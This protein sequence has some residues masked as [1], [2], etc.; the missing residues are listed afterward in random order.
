[1]NCHQRQMPRRYISL[2]NHVP[3]GKIRAVPKDLQALPQQM[4]KLVQHWGF[5]LRAAGSFNR[6]HTWKS[7]FTLVRA[8][9]SKPLATLRAHSTFTPG[10]CL[11]SLAKLFSRLPLLV[12]SPLHVT[13]HSSQPQAALRKPREPL[14]SAELLGRRESKLGGRRP[15]ACQQVARPVFGRKR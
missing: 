14:R 15:S 11:S 3:G 12:E 5:C 8:I 9:S 4:Q 1:M 7:S 2:P 6:D 13:P 10:H